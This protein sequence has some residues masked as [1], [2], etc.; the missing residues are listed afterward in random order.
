MIGSQ[1]NSRSTQKKILSLNIKAT[2]PKKQIR[3]IQKQNKSE[4]KNRNKIDRIIFK[5]ITHLI[6]FHFIRER[7]KERER[8]TA[9]AL[10]NYQWLIKNATI[11]IDSY[12]SKRTMKWNAYN[13]QLKE[14]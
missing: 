4:W 7:E 11:N 9:G 6:S 12:Q 13:D 10:T 1:Q 5:K 14:I 8:E 3:E 2:Y